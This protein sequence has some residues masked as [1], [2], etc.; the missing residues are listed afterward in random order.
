LTSDDAADDSADPG[1]LGLLAPMRGAVR[2]TGD[3]AV[4]AAMLDAET[5]LARFAAELG[6][7]ECAPASASPARPA[8]PRIS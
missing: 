4:L 1:D 7:A 8:R 3:A 5:V 2:Q 6:L